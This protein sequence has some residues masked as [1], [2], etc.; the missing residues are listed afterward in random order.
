[1]KF[2]TSAFV[3]TL[4]GSVVTSS[5]STLQTRSVQLDETTNNHLER[6]GYGRR[7]FHGHHGGFGFG[8]FGGGGF[9]G[10]FRHH[11]RY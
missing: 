4:V 6:R 1:M 9:G 2:A 8:G 5:P 11:R 10:G 7:R 3:F